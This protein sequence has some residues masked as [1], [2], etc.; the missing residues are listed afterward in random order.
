MQ[1]VLGLKMQESFKYP[2]VSSLK[3]KLIILV[4]HLQTGVTMTLPPFFSYV[5][6][7]LLESLT[8]A[9][10]S[11]SLMKTCSKETLLRTKEVPYAT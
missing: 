7:L 5:N 10:A 2:K 3:T 8:V 9:S 6:L 11:V 4:I 1:E